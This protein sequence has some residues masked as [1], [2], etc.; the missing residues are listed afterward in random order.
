MV[1]KTQ[2]RVHLCTRFE[3]ITDCTSSGSENIPDP[4]SEEL[5]L[6][7]AVVA[8]AVDDEKLPCSQDKESEVRSRI[9]ETLSYAKYI[10][11]GSIMIRRKQLAATFTSS[12]LPP[13]KLSTQWGTRAG[14]RSTNYFTQFTLKRYT[15]ENATTS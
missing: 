3:D 13:E 14:W 10:V 8:V 15:V 5:C 4:K 1:I 9:S 6:N 7:S 11:R 12:K 2:G